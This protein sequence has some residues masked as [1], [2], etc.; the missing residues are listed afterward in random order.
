MSSIVSAL[1]LERNNSLQMQAPAARNICSG[2][3]WQGFHSMGHQ[4]G[5]Y[6]CLYKMYMNVCKLHTAVQAG[7]ASAG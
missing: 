2:M 4:A 6:T 1:Q 3:L 7:S 5:I